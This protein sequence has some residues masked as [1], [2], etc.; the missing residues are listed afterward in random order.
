MP[1]FASDARA[2]ASAD[3]RLAKAAPEPAR[4]PV[5]MLARKRAMAPAADATPDVRDA[6]AAAQ[7]AKPAA[8]VAT[9]AA[10]AEA[11]AA[12]AA[13]AN[14]ADALAAVPHAEETAALGNV[15]LRAAP[16]VRPAAV[17]AAEA[18]TGHARRSIIPTKKE[19]T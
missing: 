11:G 15:L 19:E 17:R 4:T 6:V 12:P 7:A 5:R 13:L 9:A 2:G 16:A 18:A 1:A 14:A 3:A 10:A 8:V